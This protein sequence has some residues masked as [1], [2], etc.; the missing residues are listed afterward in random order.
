[1]NMRDYLTL[2]L[3]T[4]KSEGTALLYGQVQVLAVS[5]GTALLYGQVQVLAVFEGTALLYGQVQVLAVFTLSFLG[6]CR[7]RPTALQ[8]ML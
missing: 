3:V 1:M 5:E 8:R 4:N 7:I 6:K 2:H